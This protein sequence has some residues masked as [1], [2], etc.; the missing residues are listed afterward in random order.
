MLWLAVVLFLTSGL[1]LLFALTG[2]DKTHLGDGEDPQVIP[3]S[4]EQ[5]QCPLKL[6]HEP[7]EW[8]KPRDC[9]G[10]PEQ[11]LESREAGEL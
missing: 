3:V 8:A 6:P 7:H 2:D 5:E 11:V 10:V 1:I 4:K 9:A